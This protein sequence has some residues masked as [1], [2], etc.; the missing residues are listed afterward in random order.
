M[1]LSFSCWNHHLRSTGELLASYQGHVH[2]SVKMDACLTPSDAHV[3]G[4]SETGKLK[5]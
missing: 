2:E 5:A 3:V 1:S 4:C